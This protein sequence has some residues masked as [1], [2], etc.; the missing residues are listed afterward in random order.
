MEEGES[1]ELCVSFLSLSFINRE[2]AENRTISFMLRQLDHKNPVNLGKLRPQLQ[3]R[4]QLED[5]PVLSQ[6]E[7]TL[8]VCLLLLC[9]PVFP[10]NRTLCVVAFQ[11]PNGF[12]PLWLPNQNCNLSLTTF[13]SH[14]LILGF[15][16]SYAY[17]IV[18]IK[19]MLHEGMT[20]AFRCSS[21]YLNISRFSLCTGINLHF[22]RNLE[23]FYDKSCVYSLLGIS[24]A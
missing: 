14:C 24:Y 6:H 5:Y 4:Q 12:W 10:S 15:T 7:I 22:P 1:W 21:S 17:R 3:L 23:V 18:S 13:L 9:F 16:F 20:A 8:G 19:A 2:G 11:E